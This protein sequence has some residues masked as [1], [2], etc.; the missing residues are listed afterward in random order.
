LTTATIP[1]SGKSN[2]KK[3][4]DSRDSAIANL[5]DLFCAIAV[6]FSLQMA[7]FPVVM[8][9]LLRTFILSVG[10]ISVPKRRI[11]AQIAE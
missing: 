6:F 2:P 1:E 5:G 11:W 9:R 4:F 7:D 10:S 3:V 8:W